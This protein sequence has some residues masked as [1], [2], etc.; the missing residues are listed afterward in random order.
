MVHKDAEALNREKVHDFF[1]SYNLREISMVEGGQDEGKTKD[2]V[3]KVREGQMKDQNCCVCVQVRNFVRVPGHGYVWKVKVCSLHL[4]PFCKNAHLSRT[5]GRASSV[6]R[7]A[8]APIEITVAAFAMKTALLLFISSEWQPEKFPLRE[9]V[10][11]AK[12]SSSSSEVEL[13]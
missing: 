9:E 12:L 5:Y 11:Q 1:Y 8:G 6:I 4:A 3:E 13:I 2:A 7:F 10:V